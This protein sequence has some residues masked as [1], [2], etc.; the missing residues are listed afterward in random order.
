MK[1]LFLLCLLKLLTDN[2]IY[3]QNRKHDGD[4][5]PAVYV[6]ATL[7]RIRGSNVDSN[8]CNGRWLC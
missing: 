1:H 6:D 4:T 2:K 8:F 3:K 7:H 5:C